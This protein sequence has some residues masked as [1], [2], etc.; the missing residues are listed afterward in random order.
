MELVAGGWELTD[1]PVDYVIAGGPLHMSRSMLKRSMRYFQC[2][3]DSVSIAAR[4]APRI[5]HGKVDGYYKCLQVLEDLS[6]FHLLPHFPALKNAHFQAIALGMELPPIGP[7]A[8]IEDAAAALAVDDGVDDVVDPAL[9]MEVVGGAV[10][11]HAGDHG[12]DAALAGIAL[13]PPP[14]LDGARCVR[15]AGRTIRFD[16]WSHVSGVRRGYVTCRH[17]GRHHHCFKYQHL[18]NFGYDYDLCA[19]VPGA[20]PT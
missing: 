20:H 7:I 8:A 16:N 9:P 1:A 15:V 6:G 13:A 18:T 11:D 2:L 17:N 4:G 5:M 3:L 10:A 12:V 19:A 14:P